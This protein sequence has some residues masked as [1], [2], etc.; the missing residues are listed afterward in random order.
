[1]SVLPFSTET[2][3]YFPSTSFDQDLE[4]ELSAAAA[5]GSIISVKALKPLKKQ[6][7]THSILKYTKEAYENEQEAAHKGENLAATRIGLLATVCHVVCSCDLARFDRSTV[8]QVSTMVI[9]GLS[10]SLF[11]QSN[12]SVDAWKTIAKNLVLAANLK[13]LCLVPDVVSFQQ[14]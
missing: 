9:E 12:T 14:E 4:L 13:V 1:M 7:L 10:S 5:Y 8:Q 2:D 6:R 3:Q 11:S